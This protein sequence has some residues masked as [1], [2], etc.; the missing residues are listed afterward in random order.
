MR[1]LFEI[2]C[3]ESCAAQFVEKSRQFCPVLEPFSG[4]R[5]LAAE[6]AHRRFRNEPAEIEAEGHVLHADRLSDVNR[7]AHKAIHIL[8]R[9]ICADKFVERIQ[10]DKAAAFGDRS[11]LIV[12]EIARHRRQQRGHWNATR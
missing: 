6:A 4:W 7:L 9:W 3:A 2:V 5:I 8:L 1:D 11:Q 10:P 12:R